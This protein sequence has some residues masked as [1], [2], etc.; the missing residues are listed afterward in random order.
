MYAVQKTVT[1]KTDNSMIEC[2]ARHK[3]KKMN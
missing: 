3:T 1:H 2:V